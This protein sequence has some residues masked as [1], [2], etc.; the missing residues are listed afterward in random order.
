MIPM[1]KLLLTGAYGMVGYY[2][3]GGIRLGRNDLDI[4]SIDLVK[5]VVVEHAPTIILNLAAETDLA[6]CEREPETAYRVNAMGAYNLALAARSVGAKLVHV[7]TSGVFDGEK[8]TPYVESDHPNPINVYGHSKYLSELAVL[9]VS[10]KN[11]VVR[12]SW[13]FGGGA[14]RDKKFVGMMIKKIKEGDVSAV[15][16]RYGSPTYAK[17]L[18]ARIYELIAEGAS[19]VR[20]VAGAGSVSR[21][22][23]AQEIARCLQSQAKVTPVSAEVFPQLYRSGRNE[24]VISLHMRPWQEALKEYI[25]QEWKEV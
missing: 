22:E 2:I 6:L 18:V 1:E 16:D 23:V 11:L 15:S 21:F 25:A 12:T 17:D 7:S 14:E 8:E 19:G 3:I 24:G 4:T 10:D 9:G 5:K 13:V 20:H